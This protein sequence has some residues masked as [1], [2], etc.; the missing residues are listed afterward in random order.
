MKLTDTAVDRIPIPE[1]GKAPSWLRDSDHKDAVSG[2]AIR[3][4]SGGVRTFILNYRTKGGRQRQYTI[5]SRP[6]WGCIAARKRAAELRR[7]VDT[8][9]DP[10]EIVKTERDAPT[11]VDLCD[12]AL[13]EHYADVRESTRK[14]V[15]AQIDNYIRPAFGARKVKDINREDINALHRKI[16]ETAPYQAN[17]VRATLNTLFNIAIG[18]PRRWQINNNPVKGSRR[19]EENKRERYLGREDKDELKRFLTALAS[20]PETRAARV[21]DEKKAVVRKAAEQARDIIFL[22]LVTGARQGE[23]RAMRWPYYDAKEGR[24]AGI[25]LTAAIWTKPN[26]QTKQN[27]LHDVAL[28]PEAIECLQRLR[29]SAEPDATYVF[30]GRGGKGFRTQIKND[31]EILCRDAGLIDAKTGKRN[32]RLH[33]L[34]HSFASLGANAGLTLQEVGGLLGH[35]NAATTARYVHLFKDKERSATAKIGKTISSAQSAEIVDHPEKEEKTFNRA[36]VA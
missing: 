23:V 19:N 31:W 5:G 34:R 18:E 28:S 8:G 33:D 26:S 30:P 1:K 14:N 3:V 9:Q 21:P 10:A 29:A 11:M 36:G 35:S 32:M 7:M 2:F 12:S 25:S 15:E 22:A 16:S 20:Y 27:K 17:R 4:T 6:S 13:R 24:I